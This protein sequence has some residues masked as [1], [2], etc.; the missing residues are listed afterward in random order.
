MQRDEIVAAVRRRTGA[1]PS[2]TVQGNDK[3]ALE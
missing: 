1:T 3:E 2:A